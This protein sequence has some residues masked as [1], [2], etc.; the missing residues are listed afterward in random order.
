[1]R[2]WQLD[3]DAQKQMSEVESTL[4][5]KHA[6]AR[7]LGVSPDGV[8]KLVASRQIPAI[9]L[10]HR[11]LRFAWP[12]VEKALAKLTIPEITR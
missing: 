7:R 8:L 12:Q 2:W 6:L 3:T 9:K 10:G 5:D 4:L 11:T 1:M